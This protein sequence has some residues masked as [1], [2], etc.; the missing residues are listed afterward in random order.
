[1]FCFLRVF[2][3]RLRE[4]DLVDPENPEGHFPLTEYVCTRWYRAPE[5]LCNQVPFTFDEDKNFNF[6]MNMSSQTC[7]C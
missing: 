4:L 3:A 6:I 7:S 2:K 5:V 1:M